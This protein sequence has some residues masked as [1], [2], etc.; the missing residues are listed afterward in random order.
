VSTSV[1]AFIGYLK[2]GT[3]NKAFQI[4]NMGDFEREFGGLDS[5]SE[6]SYAVH[7]FFLN[8]GKEAW[9]VRTASG[10]VFKAYV[11]IS[12]AI[13]GQCALKVE[14]ISEGEWGNNIRVSIDHETSDPA[15]LFNMTVSQYVSSG[16]EMQL[17]SSEVFRNLSMVSSQTR[18]VETVVNDETSGSKLVRVTVNQSNINRPLQNGTV[19][20]DLSTFQTLTKVSGPW[21]V[22]VQIGTDG[23][24]PAVFSG[25]PG[26]LSEARSI[27]E[28]AIRSAKP[29][30]PAFA[31]AKVEII[32]DCLRIL[33]GPTDSSNCVHFGPS[34]PD[35][36]LSEL[37]LVSTNTTNV[38]CV[39]SPEID[40]TIF[41]TLAPPAF[42][43]VKMNS[44]GPYKVDLG[45]PNNID[46][47]SKSLENGIRGIPDTHPNTTE[48]EAFANAHVVVVD[49]CLLVIPGDYQATIEFDDDN[50][51]YLAVGAL[52][53]DNLTEV[54]GVLSSDLSAFDGLTYNP[55]KIEVKISSVTDSSEVFIQKSPGDI[56]TIIEARQYLELGIRSADPNS[57]TTFTKANVVIVGNSLLTIPGDAGD[58]ITFEEALIDS[59]TVNDLLLNTNSSNP[60]AD[61]NVQEYTLGNT[62]AISG[63]AQGQGDAGQNG[64]PPDGTALLGNMNDKTGIYAL[65]DVDTFNILCIPRTA[66]VGPN[67]MTPT[68]AEFVMSTAI[69]YC[70]KRR[71]FFIMDTPLGVD[72]VQEVKDWLGSTNLRDKNSALYFPRIKIPDPL[73]DFRLRSVGASG[74]V[75]GLYAR[76]DSNNGVWKAPAGTDAKLVNVQAL[77][78]TLTDMQNGTLNPLGINCL[79][80]LPVYGK[81]CWGARTLDGADQMTSEWKY[82]PVRRLALLIEE[83]LYR[84]LTWVV[85]E[86]ND[87]PLWSQ[88][89]LNVGSFMHRLFRQGAFQGTTAREAYLVKCDKETTIQADIDLG[90]VNIV[91]G[92]AP[93]KP[94][95][96][97]IIKIKQLAGQT[98][99]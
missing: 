55:A 53:L 92:F 14:A 47:A 90:V 54:N 60:D 2:Q 79:R 11:E 48:N 7:Q 21:I 19:S 12:D 45:E 91:V 26:F 38:V 96:F 23:P 72:D 93:L 16:G 69:K 77:D 65:E 22:N 39:Q 75:A 86:P 35:P 73:N 25:V 81:I 8:G 57:S 80:S 95:E 33:A 76:I 34:D 97:V 1:A 15:T 10:S 30:N 99:A 58:S 88:I 61:A 9:V 98:Q 18:Y 56:K 42:I 51:S 40:P 82:I 84:G 64:S 78:Y 59:D 87:E 50:G 43:G 62:S 63:T 83:S 13:N 68:E 3:I 24:Y 32:Q 4:F 74:T 20:G 31:S 71:A 89:R 66:I 5:K 27:L 29:D 85:F 44:D 36:A 67:A 37:G 70:E 6:V 41:T 17:N 49:D 46:E 52:G 94:A 28:A